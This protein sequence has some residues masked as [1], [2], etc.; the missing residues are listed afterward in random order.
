VFSGVLGYT[1]VAFLGVIIFLYRIPKLTSY[2]DRT[3]TCCVLEY[4]SQLR[5]LN[6]THAVKPAQCRIEITRLEVDKYLSSMDS[7]N[8]NL[9]PP[10]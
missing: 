7:Q 2:I 5:R 9:F 4:G 1:G 3:C 10:S 6:R 8:L